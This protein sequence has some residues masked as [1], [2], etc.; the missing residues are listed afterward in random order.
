[1]SKRPTEIVSVPDSTEQARCD[2]G[3]GALGHPLVFL[4][5]DGQSVVDCYYCS[6]RFIKSGFREQCEANGQDVA[7]PL[8]E[9]TV[10]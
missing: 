6:R 2:G 3:L 4:P 8:A 5:F 9:L 7:A 1:M 10:S